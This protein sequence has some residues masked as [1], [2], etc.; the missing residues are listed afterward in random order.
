M[1]NEGGIVEFSVIPGVSAFFAV[2]RE[3]RGNGP[4]VCGSGPPVSVLHS[5][6][7]SERVRVLPS[8]DAK[9]AHQDARSDHFVLQPLQDPHVRVVSAL[10][11]RAALAQFVSNCTSLMRT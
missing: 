1:Y 4:N 7:V 2:I 3:A 10:P 5:K 6:S 9:S 8:G 11:G